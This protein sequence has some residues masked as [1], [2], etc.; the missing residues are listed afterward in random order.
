MAVG[1]Q[2]PGPPPLRPFGLILRH[3][4]SWIHE[5]QPILNQ[6]LRAAF[7]HGV[8]FLPGEGADGEDVYVVALGRFRGQIEVEEAGFFV[9]MF[10]AQTGALALS[11]RSTETLEVASLHLSEH[12][13]AVLCRVKR[14][15]HPTGLLARFSH[16]AQ[17]ELFH[18]VQEDES[19][20]FLSIGGARESLPDL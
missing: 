17:A 6:R 1:S 4:G 16:A 18:A 12:G 8:C 11:D 14:D 20:A 3:D 2:V 10:D 7:D 13:G 9:R 19:G 15:L 5:G